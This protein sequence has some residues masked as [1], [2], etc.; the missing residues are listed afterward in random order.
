MDC[1]IDG[2]VVDVRHHLRED[3]HEHAEDAVLLHEGT[4]IRHSEPG[5][6]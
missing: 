1:V 3:D 5:T 4:D 6:E 2:E